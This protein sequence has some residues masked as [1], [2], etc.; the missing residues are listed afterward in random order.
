M[1]VRSD[2]MR[3]IDRSD[4]DEKKFRLNRHV[5][6]TARLTAHGSRLTA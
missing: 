3:L 6:C 2:M 1:L 5:R 4:V